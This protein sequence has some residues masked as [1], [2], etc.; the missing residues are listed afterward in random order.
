M[1]SSVIDLLTGYFSEELIKER[2]EMRSS[3]YNGGADG[4]AEVRAE[5]ADLLRDR[6][7]SH[8]DFWRATSAWFDSDEDLYR[9][10]EEAYR[11]FFDEEPPVS[12]R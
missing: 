5:F 7:M 10:L 3:L 1:N 9:E 2:P 12:A 4:V 8:D 6:T 11:F